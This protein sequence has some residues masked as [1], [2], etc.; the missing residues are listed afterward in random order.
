MIDWRRPILVMTM[1]VALAGCAPHAGVKSDVAIAPIAVSGS[2]ATIE[3]APV[4]LA[5]R[6]LYPAGATVSNGGIPNLFDASRPADIATHAETQALRYSVAHPDI[7]IILTV[8]EGRYR[9]IARRSAGIGRIADLKGKRIATLATTSAGYFLARM[10]AQEGLSFADITPVRIS[11]LAG[12]GPALERR[13]VDAVAI[14]EPHGGNAA[15]ALGD[16]I[17]I[18]SGD[19]VYRELFNLNTTAANLADPAKRRRIT[20]FVRAVIA[21]SARIRRDPAP[22][23]ALVAATAGFGAEEVAG[24]WPTLSFPAALPADLLDELVAQEQWLATQDK[25]PPRSREA[26]SQLIDTSIYN[27]ALAMGPLAR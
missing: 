10:L 13:E 7:R 25:R 26:L 22:A 15:R 8:T 18:F 2:T 24:A 4:L 3:I 21:A 16:D 11:P 14:W 9:I 1:L 23:Q 19:G 27:D 12:I 20:E 17:V 5:A 6:N